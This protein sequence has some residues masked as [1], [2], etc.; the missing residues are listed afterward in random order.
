[1]EGLFWSVIFTLWMVIVAHF[2]SPWWMI[3][4]LTPLP[5]LMVCVWPVAKAVFQGKLRKPDDL[6]DSER[7]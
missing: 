3:V 1:M 5:I 4:L 7:N 2:A 6:I